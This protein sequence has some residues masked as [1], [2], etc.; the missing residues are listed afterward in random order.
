MRDS[1]STCGIAWPHFTESRFRGHLVIS[2][3]KE[4]L[5]ELHAVCQPVVN[6]D[7]QACVSLTR[8]NDF[9]G[10]A[11]RRSAFRNDVLGKIT[12]SQW[13]QVPP[14]KPG[15]E[16]KHKESRG[17]NQFPLLRNA[18]KHTLSQQ[19]LAAIGRPRRASQIAGGKF[20]QLSSFRSHLWDCGWPI[21]GVNL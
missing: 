8:A 6:S 12:C 4:T 3:L 13:S 9:Y 7:L 16:A 10:I 5:T 17:G 11:R 20:T 18:H 21:L 14:L 1:T 19:W 2:R 15:K